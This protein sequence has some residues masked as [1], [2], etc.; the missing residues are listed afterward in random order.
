MKNFLLDFKKQEKFLRSDISRF[1]KVDTFKRVWDDFGG[2]NEDNLP[3][4]S[5]NNVELVHLGGNRMKV[6]TWPMIVGSENTPPD[7]I[8]FVDVSNYPL[9]VE[10]H[11]HLRRTY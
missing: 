6:I 3:S 5:Y 10:L 11:R 9:V 1:G 7:K 2:L 4:L 8:E